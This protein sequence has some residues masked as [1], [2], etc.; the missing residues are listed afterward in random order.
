MS[1]TDP[2]TVTSPQDQW[3]LG[4]ILY[5]SREYGWSVAEG[6]WK[7]GETWNNALGIRWNGG[8]ENPLGHPISHFHPVWFI[9]PDELRDV[10]RE[11]I[12]LLPKP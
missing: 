12:A 4:S 8:G 1:Y 3:K 5:N 6:Q 9:V 10:L 11:V 7:D 2:R